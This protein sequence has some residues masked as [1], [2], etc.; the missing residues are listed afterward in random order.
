MT[1]KPR[2]TIIGHG[3]TIGMVETEVSP[4]QIVLMPAKNAKELLTQTSLDTQESADYTLIDF[5]NE[6]STNL[7]PNHWIKLAKKIKELQDSG[8]VDGIIVTHGTDTMAYN[9][10]AC[11]LA[12]GHFLKIPVI[13]TGSQKPISQSGSDGQINL[14]DSVSTVVRSIELHLNR[15]MVVFNR[16]IILG[17]RAMKIN[18]S[19]FDAFDSPAFSVLG[20]ITAQGVQFGPAALTITNGR[21]KTGPFLA[22]FNFKTVTIELSPGL[23]P[24][25]VM[26]ILKTGKCDGLILK[27]FGAGNVPDKFEGFS[28]IPLIKEAS[29]KYK[30]PIL[31]STQFVGGSTHMDVY[32]PGQNAIN[33]G[34]IPTGDMTHIMSQVKLMWL[35]AQKE[36][37]NLD[38]LKKGVIKNFIDEISS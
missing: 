37:Q 17:A 11:S 9:A 5:E 2:I 22:D 25:L 32:G 12:L 18:E 15:V 36:Y 31:V 6:D 30:I 34:A 14:E 20:E 29:Q 35:L 38:K 10:G 27:S 1:N 21:K 8:K 33:A 13:F 7:N 28:L 19:R 26:A 3:G 23:D 24:Q 16:K 4:G